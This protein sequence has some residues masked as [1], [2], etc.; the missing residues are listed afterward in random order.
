MPRAFDRRGHL[1]DQTEFEQLQD[2][3]RQ[4]RINR[5][6]QGAG[7]TTGPQTRR[8]VVPLSIEDYDRDPGDYPDSRSHDP[9]TLEALRARLV[10]RSNS[11]FE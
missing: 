2:E 5:F 9:N 11:R 6:N 1:V 10:E 8:D 4:A 3:E 7:L